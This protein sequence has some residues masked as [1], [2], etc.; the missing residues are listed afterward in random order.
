MN[1]HPSHIPFQLTRSL[2]HLGQEG[3]CSETTLRKKATQFFESETMTMVVTLKTVGFRTER[4]ILRK[5]ILGRRRLPVSFRQRKGRREQGWGNCLVGGRGLGLRA[6][7]SRTS[8]CY[9]L[10]RKARDLGF[11]WGNDKR[12]LVGHREED[13]VGQV[14]RGLAQREN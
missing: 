7:K 11:K 14:R 3:G 4:T 2:P 5:S 10:F 8:F 1:L 12:E 9:S 6:G 13:R